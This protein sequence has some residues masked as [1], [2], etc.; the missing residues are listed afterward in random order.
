LGGV[1]GADELGGG[2]GLKVLVVDDEGAVRELLG[3]VLERLG[4]EVCVAGDAEE[5]GQIWDE[6]AGDFDVLLA[7]FVLPGVRTGLDLGREL[8]SRRPSLRVI[9]ASGYGD[10]LPVDDMETEGV[11][12]LPKPFDLALLQT[13]LWAAASRGG[14]MQGEGREERG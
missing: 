11:E 6:R 2:R 1:V 14:A 12:L 13:V 7:D 5:A 4:V 3:K 8:R 9:I 10:E